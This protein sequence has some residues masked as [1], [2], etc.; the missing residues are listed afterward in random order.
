[1][2]QD[3]PDM[4][5]LHRFLH[6]STRYPDAV[7]IQDVDFQA[8]YTYGE[9]RQYAE[10]LNTRLGQLGLNQKDRILLLLPNCSTWAALYLASVGQGAIPVLINDKLTVHECAALIRKSAPTMIISKAKLIEKHKAILAELSETTK[11]VSTD[12]LPTTALGF[13]VE[14]LEHTD[15]SAT[16]LHLPEGNPVVA[17]QFTYKGLGRPLMVAHRYLSFDISTVGINRLIGRHTVGSV[18]LVSLPLYAIFGLTVLFLLPLSVGA[19]LILYPSVVRQDIINA[20]AEHRISFVCFVPDILRIL[21]KQLNDR[22]SSLPTLNPGL[23]IY[24][25]GSYLSSDLVDQIAAHIGVRVLQGYGL[26]ETLPIAAQDSFKPEIVGSIGEVIPN[27]EARIIG[28]SGQEI[29]VGQTGE[30]VVRGVNVIPEYVDDVQASQHFI[31][32]GWFFTGDLVKKDIENNIFFVGRRLRIT[33]VTAQMVD[34]GEIEDCIRQC[35]GV[36]S[37]R[38]YVKHDAYGRNILHLSVRTSSEVTQDILLA[39]LSSHLSPFKIPRE[40][41]VQTIS[42]EAL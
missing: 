6:F 5:F 15:T 20:L 10:F 36:C 11:I 26:T 40:I 35:A 28:E 9:L 3:C 38:V 41:D 25:G 7:A 39:H 37:A 29:A 22:D 13:D 12:G 17:I 2:S 8:S 24:S 4:G 31:K 18:F 27:V 14:R 33:K 16:P 23:R 19:T 32:S 1:M 34:L 42:A 21:L 30:L